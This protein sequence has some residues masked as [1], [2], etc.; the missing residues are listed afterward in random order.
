[1]DMARRK[2]LTATNTCVSDG[3]LLWRLKLIYKSKAMDKT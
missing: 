1:M 3:A 2:M